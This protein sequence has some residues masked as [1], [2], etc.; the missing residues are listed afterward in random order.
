MSAALAFDVPEAQSARE[1]AE[2]RGVRRD[3]VRMLVASRHDAAVS[4]AH[5]A[6]LP[7]LLA[8]G[9]VLVVNT[10]ATLPAAVPARRADGSPVEVHFATAA[11][12]HDDSCWWVVELRTAGGAH[13]EPGHGGEQLALAGGGQ[14][15]LVAPYVPG[16]RLWLARLGGAE[17]VLE[18]LRRNGH[19]IRYGYVP[20]PWPLDAYQ[21]AFAL[22]PGSA[23]MPSAARPFTPELVTRLVTAGVQFA[24]ITLHTGV[25]SP[26]RDEPPYP[27][28][29][30]V[31]A[32]AAR[33]VNAAER[34]VAVGTTAVRAL[35]SAAGDDGV[36]RASAGWTGLVVTPERGVRAVDGLITG[37]HEPEASHLLM[38]EAIA[39]RALLR[40][41]YAEA[42]A[43]GYLWHEFGDSHLIL[44]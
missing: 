19:P 29:Y 20:S 1:P 23:E 43:A 14:L 22:H 4:H 33:V 11:P 37:W 5:F 7:D 3:E 41:S 36:V 10:S 24:P 31:S 44:P 38:L 26:E 12:K 35:E 30:E 17:S 40:R 34:V 2:A 13:P 21:T 15:E 28:R 9:D 39:G 25:S 18:Y 6:D 27:E 8:P 16:R 42:L 32:H